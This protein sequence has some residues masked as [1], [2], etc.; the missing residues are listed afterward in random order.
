MLQ[1]LEGP[2]SLAELR[3]H[4][5]ITSSNLIPQLNKLKTAN[6]VTKD[7]GRLCLTFTGTVLA[8]HLGMIDTLMRLIEVNEQFFNEHDLSP[9]P[10]SML[11]RVGELEGCKLIENS[12]EN[13]TA[14]F[15]EVIDIISKSRH[16]SIISPTSDNYYPKFILSIAERKIPV[17]V[18]LTENIF[19]KITNEN[20]YSLKAYLGHDNARLYVVDDARLSFTV[21]DIFSSLSLYKNGSFDA[22]TSLVSLDKSGIK[23]GEDLF[24]YYRQKSK[25]IRSL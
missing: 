22:S 6:L 4:L 19:R 8:K 3:N 12:M 17:S 25:E 2:T 20:T 14:T 1:L 5:N 24:E 13:I 10:E 7:N 15:T 21:T 11:Q 9:I 23:W 16:V 18:I